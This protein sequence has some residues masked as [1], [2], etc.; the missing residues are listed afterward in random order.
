MVKVISDEP[1]A[2]AAGSPLQRLEFV[3][4]LVPWP[5]PHARPLTPV[6]PSTCCLCRM[7]IRQKARKSKPAAGLQ[8]TG[9]GPPGSTPLS[10]GKG[11]FFPQCCIL[12]LLPAGGAGDKPRRGSV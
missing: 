11:T 10:L 5:R 6:V 7:S 2:A 8:S 1:R 3:R 4:I 9:P 12:G